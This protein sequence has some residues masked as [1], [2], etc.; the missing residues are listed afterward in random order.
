MECQTAQSNTLCTNGYYGFQ[1]VLNGDMAACQQNA[2]VA[3]LPNGANG[4]EEWNGG[5]SS[6]AWQRKRGREDVVYGNGDA[7]VHAGEALLDCTTAKVNSR[8]FSTVHV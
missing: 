3:S 6:L 5:L 4:H 2:G 8:P 1:P 7:A